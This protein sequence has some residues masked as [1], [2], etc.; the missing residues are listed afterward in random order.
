MQYRIDEIL[1]YLN[2][3]ERTVSS[4]TEPLEILAKKWSWY[5]IITNLIFMVLTLL[6]L[7]LHNLWP[8]GKFILI[9][10]LSLILLMLGGMFTLLIE[11]VIA[12]LGLFKWK[13]MSLT[14]FLREI[15]EDEAHV[16]RLSHYEEKELQYAEYLVEKKI[17][18]NEN[19][20]KFFFGEKTAVFALLAF[21]VPFMKELFGWKISLLVFSGGEGFAGYVSMLL[22]FVWALVFGMSLGAIALKISTGRYQYQQSLLKQ[23]LWM[24]KR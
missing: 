14:R 17:S 7:G 22:G 9:G 15:Q 10:Q 20:I 12:L 24:K 5:G 8:W 18:A 23:T 3:C 6:M 13:S 16:A 19:R 2:S 1:G 11:P 21:S 4:Q